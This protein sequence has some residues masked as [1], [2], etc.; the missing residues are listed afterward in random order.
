MFDTLFHYPSVLAR[1]SEG[2]FAVERE[3]YLQFCASGGTAQS[4]L[5]GMASELLV[6]ASRI[7]LTG[8]R[9]VSMAEICI[10]ADQWVGYQRRQ[11]H[12]TSIKYSRER[13]IYTAT[14]W[15]RFLGR[16]EYPD[17]PLPAFAC[18]VDAFA[19]CMLKERGLSPKTVHNYCWHAHTFL[20][21]LEEQG[22]CLADLRLDQID[23]FMALKGSQGWCRVSISSIVYA[24]RAFLRY[25]AE[26]GRCSAQLGAG[27]EGPR[28]F[29]Q[30]G[31]PVGPS[32]TDVR[33]LVASVDTDHPRDIRDRAIFLLLAVYGLR[34][35]EVTTLTLA[36]VDWEKN[37]LHVSR[38]K[39]RRRQDYP[40][41]AEVGEAILRYLQDARPRCLC[42]SLFL[43]VK[44]PIRRLD[45]S[46][47]HYLV[48]SRMDAQGIDCA[49]RNPHALRHACAARLVAEAFSL[50]QIGD[51]LGHRSPYATRTYAKVDLA[52]LRQVA[53]VDL[54]E[55]L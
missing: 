5:L 35:G 10:A 30:E 15:C 8:S 43:T 53:D 36:D 17:C 40:L 48:R 3:Q 28:L 6:I 2:P 22:T 18:A 11:H 49:R 55:L 25:S 39:Q 42:R 34:A 14:S 13:F 23:T 41:T 29:R 44:A 21:W 4:T 50:K 37:L 32:W 33:R 26:H 12:I 24:L 27:I 51:H 52:G 54:G 19:D 46:S 1:H 16:L 47:L 45:S 31:L 20:L 9:I 38:P 7:D